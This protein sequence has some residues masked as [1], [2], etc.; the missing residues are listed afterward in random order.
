MSEFSNDDKYLKKEVK[1]VPTPQKK[2]LGG[3]LVEQGILTIFTVERILVLSAKA[4]KRFGTILEELGLVTGEELAQALA[5]QYGCKT[6]FD[7][8]QYQFPADV[9]RLVPVETAVEH[10]VFP[11]KIQGNTLVLA[12]VDPTNEKLINNLA[13]NSKMRVYTLI[14][15]R[16]E[17]KKAIARH[18]LKKD[19]TETDDITIL[20]VEDDKLISLMITNILRKEGYR[21]ITALN[22][23]EAFKEIIASKPNLILTDK[24]MPMFDGYA[25]LESLRHIPE[26]N[27]IPVILLSES[28]D[29]DEESN[30]YEKGFF[31]YLTKP[32]KENTLKAK[33]KRALRAKPFFSN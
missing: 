15:S 18:Y 4:R 13:E 23:M 20:V 22:G 31:D 6:V 5:I 2:K 21:I 29:P 30:A 16:K 14:T 24:E 28:A 1:A 8:W 12:V 17:I 11:L 26:T 32:I 7:F 33:V 27:M 9:L 25:L 3:I 19:L 10:T